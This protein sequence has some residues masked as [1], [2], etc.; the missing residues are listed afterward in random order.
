MFKD[1][2]LLL[3]VSVFSLISYRTDCPKIES[4]LGAGLY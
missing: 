3:A 4:W 1:D 2:M